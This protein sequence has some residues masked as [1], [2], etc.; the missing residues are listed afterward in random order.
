MLRS[1][2]ILH[3]INLITIGAK[4]RDI[5]N[6]DTINTYNIYTINTFIVME[7]I[8]SLDLIKRIT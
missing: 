5:Y 6:I 2:K 3:F 8:K 1:E 4:G 7:Y